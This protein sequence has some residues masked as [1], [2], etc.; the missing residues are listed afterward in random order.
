M[1]CSYCAFVGASPTA[2]KWPFIV[3]MEGAVDLAAA[4][5]LRPFTWVLA[6]EDMTG[7]RTG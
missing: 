7:T 5:G 1:P 4:E 2:A 3:I 6:A